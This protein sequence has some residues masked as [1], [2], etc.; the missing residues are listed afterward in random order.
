MSVEGYYTAE[1]RKLE[2]IYKKY[3]QNNPLPVPSKEQVEWLEAEI[4]MFI[5][6]GINTFY[7]KEWSFQQYLLD[8]HH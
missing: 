1:V 7:N 4:G 5:H 6:F 8:F 3:L 2:E